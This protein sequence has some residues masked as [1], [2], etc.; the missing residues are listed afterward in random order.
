MGKTESIV[1]TLKHELMKG[2]YPVGS[3]FPSE[4]ELADRFTVNKKTANK[5]V[6]LLVSDGLL[7]RGRGGKGTIVC[8]VSKFPKYH[9]VYLGSLKHSYFA[10]L[11]HGIQTAALENNSLMS[12][13]TPTIEQFHS[14]LQMLNNSNIDGILTS[15][16]GLLPDMKKPVIYLEDQNGTIEYPEYVACDSYAAGYQIMREIIARG[17]RNIVILFHYMNNPKRLDG[18]Y[19]AMKEAGISDYR[20]RTFVSMDFTQGES[21]MLLKQIQKKFPGFT[22]IAACSDDDTFRMIKSM[23]RS[24]IQ[25]EGKIA[26]TGI[27]NMPEIVSCY[28]IATVEQHPFRI[29]GIAFRKLLEKIKKPELQIR[30]MVD[31]EVINVKNIPVR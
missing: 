3:K 14:V 17:H 10:K 20:E 22:T 7:E 15:S 29:G 6:S 9:I 13:V 26:M 12:V 21:N 27:G 8:A 24:S 2:I 28:P 23:Q 4:Y 18:F 1:Q 30:E 5:A 11:G 25:W 31:V 16:F 19:D